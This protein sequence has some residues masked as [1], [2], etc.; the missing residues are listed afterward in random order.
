[1]I[2]IWAYSLLCG[3]SP[4]ILR[5][6]VMFSFVAL[7][8]IVKN[9]PNVNNTLA[10]SAFV[11]LLFDSNMIANV[12]FQ[13]SFLAVF[14]IVNI[15]KYF[16][17]WFSFNSKISNE[18]WNI[19]SV[20]IAAQLAT[21]PLGL[22]YFHQF[23]IYFIVSNLLIIP[24][25]TFVIFIAIAMIFM[26]GLAQLFSIF[27]YAAMALGWMVKWLIFITNIIV[28]WLEKLPFSF[29]SGIQI[30]AIETILIF[31][32][33]AYTSSY[34]ITRK[35]YLAKLGLVFFI[36][37]FS[38]N[39]YED[40]KI[41]HQKFITVY[42]INQTFAMQIFDGKKSILI[43]DSSL[44]NNAD[45]FHFHI[46]QHIWACGITDIDTILFSNNLQISLNKMK[47]NI[48]KSIL[49]NYINILTQKTFIDTNLL[50]NNS[51]SVIISSK[52]K[53]NQGQTI[54]KFLSYKNINVNNVMENDAFTFN[55]EP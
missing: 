52:L 44:L 49:P 20:S 23:P 51:D 39:A 46:Q 24:L 3:L 50:G 9:K 12:G 22:F 41:Q 7:G 54:S 11:L 31:I 4:S 34:F 35:Q 37:V 38:V 43:A 40:Y 29:I 15:Q 25:T 1:L 16:K 30:N 18:V 2:I 55:I 17:Q 27:T 45:K 19:V 36:L 47:L 13:L 48:G 21:F 33:V 10:A 6:S 14:G 5:A 26:A 53:T 8:N 28:L 32:A 42:N